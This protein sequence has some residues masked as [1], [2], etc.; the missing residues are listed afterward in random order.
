[1]LGRC[2]PGRVTKQYTPE[3]EIVERF[4]GYRFHIGRV[5]NARFWFCVP[6]KSTDRELGSLIRGGKVLPSGMISAFTCLSSSS[7]FG[8]SEG[9]AGNCESL[10][11]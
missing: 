5:M 3:P 10:G 11:E 1:M 4:D 2:R 8:P 6:Q 7:K 9:R